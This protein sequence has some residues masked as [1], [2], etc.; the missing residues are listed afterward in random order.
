MGFAEDIKKF[1]E[2]AT[3]AA[4]NSVCKAAESLFSDVIVLSP[5]SPT[6]QGPYSTGVVKG[7]WY[8]A[9]NSVDSSSTTSPDPS[10]ASSLSRMKAVMAAKPFM[11]KDAVVT[12]TNS[13][14]YIQFVEYIG[15]PQGYPN[16]SGWKWSG[17]ATPYAMVST[18]IMNFKGVY[19]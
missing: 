15:W 4:N 11:G 2:K 14:P 7:N 6:R 3:L 12:F 13:T 16:P 19:T 9:I 10:G 1:Q 17:K 18:A 8:T 5:N